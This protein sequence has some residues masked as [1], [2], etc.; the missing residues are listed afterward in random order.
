MRGTR[1]ILSQ[2]PPAIEEPAVFIEV[3]AVSENPPA[4]DQAREFDNAHL[5]WIA[6]AHGELEKIIYLVE[7]MKV[8]LF[9]QYAPRMC[10]PLLYLAIHPKYK[11]PKTQKNIE[12]IFDFLVKAGVYPFEEWFVSALVSNWFSLVV[13]DKIPKL[14]DSHGVTGYDYRSDPELLQIRMNIINKLIAAGY[15]MKSGYDSSGKPSLLYLAAVSNNREL[16]FFL[17]SKGADLNTQVSMGD[18]YNRHTP[19]SRAIQNRYFTL[20][21]ELIA[22]ALNLAEQG[23]CDMKAVMGPAILVVIEDTSGSGLP[24]AGKT[25]PFELFEYL[26]RYGADTTGALHLLIEWRYEYIR[27]NRVRFARALLAAG[28]DLYYQKSMPL[29]QDFEPML[30]SGEYR[31]FTACEYA[32]Y[33]LINSPHFSDLERSSLEGFIKMIR[34]F[35]LASSLDRFFGRFRPLVNMIQ[36]YDSLYCK[37]ASTKSANCL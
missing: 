31:N 25:D 12:K 27:Q 16:C 10:T 13:M 11:T 2:M 21:K 14:P 22:Y 30:Y 26:I 28:A 37:K 15:G 5:L 8:N 17:L 3:P 29:V 18:R 23:K 35:A 34:A 9:P 7:V 20:A 6:V 19:I 1:F 32:E 4:F 36:D 24:R 33:M